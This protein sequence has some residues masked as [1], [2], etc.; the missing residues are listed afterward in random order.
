MTR[1]K[2]ADRLTYLWLA[3]LVFSLLILLTPLEIV[4][5]RASYWLL[6]IILTGL[7]VLNWFDK[8]TVKTGVIA[9]VVFILINGG[10]ITFS[11]FLDWRGEWKTQTITYRHVVH[12]NR[13]IEFQLQNTGSFGYNRRHVDRLKLLPFLEWNREVDITSIDSSIWQK[14][15]EHVNEMGLKGG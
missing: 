12:S 10:I 1:S 8:R 9:A 6:S 7:T 3:V 14:V 5:F 11:T 2:V 15:H 4:P 13:T